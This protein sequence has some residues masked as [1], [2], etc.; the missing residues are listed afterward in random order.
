MEELKIQFSSLES[1]VADILD[2]VHQLKSGCLA[3]ETYQADLEFLIGCFVQLQDDTK[4]INRT[5]IQH[6][7]QAQIRVARREAAK[8]SAALP[9]A[10]GQAEHVCRELGMPFHDTSSA[11]S[12][13]NLAKLENT[14]FDCMALLAQIGCS[15][16]I[17]VSPLRRSEAE[18]SRSNDLDHDSDG[19]TIN[20]SVPTERICE[21]L[22][23]LPNICAG[24]D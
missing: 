6:A 15:I 10:V 19:V 22:E 4:Q 14:S 5:D 24:A 17:L 11:T 7:F 1:P 18:S 20:V 13:R 21:L 3:F 16:G 9:S 12:L 2:V 8:L 23:Y